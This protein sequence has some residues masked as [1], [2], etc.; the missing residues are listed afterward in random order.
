MYVNMH[1]YR[2]AEN[3]FCV[4]ICTAL[5]YDNIIGIIIK[6]AQYNANDIQI[7]S[8]YNRKIVFVSWLNIVNYTIV[9]Q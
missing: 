1:I 7:I 4:Y 5:N 6:S 2:S 3:D 8:K 9:H